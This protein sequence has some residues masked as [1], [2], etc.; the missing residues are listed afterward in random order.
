MTMMA[1]LHEMLGYVACGLVL[2]ASA[3]DSMR[4]L[5]MVAIASNVSFLAHAS[6]MSVRA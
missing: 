5:R 6:L 3:M 1:M 2:C 4:L